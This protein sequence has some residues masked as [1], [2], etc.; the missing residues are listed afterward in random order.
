MSVSIGTRPSRTQQPGDGAGAVE[1]GLQ[2]DGWLA[3]AAEQL[4]ALGEELAIRA[5]I[6]PARYEQV[7]PLESLQ[8]VAEH[9]A[10]SLAQHILP[11]LDDQVWPDTQDLAVEGR[12]M[13][14][15]EG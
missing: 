10:V 3:C 6:I 9:G 4:V 2:R 13:Q 12:V 14:C 1:R 11:N 8:T 7:R 5:L 15:A